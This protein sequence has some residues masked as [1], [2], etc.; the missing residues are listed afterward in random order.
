MSTDEEAI[1]VLLEKLESLEKRD[2]ARE[3]QMQ[4]LRRKVEELENGR[5]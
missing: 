2:E 4:W 3:T 1:K 5:L